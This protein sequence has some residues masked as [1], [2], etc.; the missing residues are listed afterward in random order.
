MSEPQPTPPPLLTVRTALVLTLGLLAGIIVGVLA[1]VA[2]HSVWT[3]VLAGI[4]TTGAA[5][6][7]FHK[8]IG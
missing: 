6:L 7:G 3:G 4:L 1:A 8:V 2:E 5:V